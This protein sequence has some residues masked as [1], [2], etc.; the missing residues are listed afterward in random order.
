MDHPKVI[1]TRFILAKKQKAKQKK[2]ADTKADIEPRAVDLLGENT[3][4]QWAIVLTA[5]IALYAFSIFLFPNNILKNYDFLLGGDNLAAAPIAKMGQD[6]QA[7]GSVPDW[8]PYIFCGMP[9]VGS[10][11]Y[12]N[13]YYY[14]FYPMINSILSVISSISLARWYNF[15]ANFLRLS[16]SMSRSMSG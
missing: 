10:L 3:L 14:A 15:Y 12:A 2:E 1:N 16:L 13:H 5:L 9:M 4:P 8:C 11:I 7:E 6:F